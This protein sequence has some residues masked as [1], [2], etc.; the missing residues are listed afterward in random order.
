MPIGNLH[1]KSRKRVKDAQNN[2][3]QQDFPVPR[4]LFFSPEHDRQLLVYF[5][6]GIN[7]QFG[8]DIFP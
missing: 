3:Q 6:E 1:E 5:Y 2:Q 4:D 8:Q 7:I